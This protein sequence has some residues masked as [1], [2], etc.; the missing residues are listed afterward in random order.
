MNRKL[1]MTDADV[2]NSYPTLAPADLDAAWEYF[3]ANPLEIER[4]I[5]LND[6]AANV[7]DG[8]RPPAW[9]IVSGRMLGLSDDEI[10]TAFAPPLS[11]AD[12]DAAWAE[13]RSDPCRVRGD[14]TGTTTTTCTQS[15]RT[16]PASSPAPTTPTFPPSPTAFTPQLSRSRLSSV[17]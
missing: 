6:T 14:V 15:I 16:T 2:L 10:R 12:L 8:V 1:G 7:P 11:P 5:W 17:N 3:R 4:A 13:Y 9:M